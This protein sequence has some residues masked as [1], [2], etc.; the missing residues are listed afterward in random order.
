MTKIKNINGT[1]VNTCKCGSWLEHW[2]KYSNQ[3]VDY[4]SEITCLN[5]VDLVG[6]HVQIAN[7]TE[8]S[9]Y[10]IP[11]CK[12]HNAYTGEMDIVANRAMVLA[13]KKLTCDK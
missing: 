7:S 13:N 6:A 2:K 5:N 10:I 3:D 8:M 11:L 4:C 9:W 1:S 12:T